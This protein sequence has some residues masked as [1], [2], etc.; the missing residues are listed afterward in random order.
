MSAQW[1]GEGLPP[2]GAVLQVAPQ[3]KSESGTVEVVGSHEARI[4]CVRLDGDEIGS[5]RS[6][7]ANELVPIHTPEQIAEDE[8]HAAI[9]HMVLQ[10]LGRCD[11][12][13]AAYIYDVGYRR[14][15][16]RAK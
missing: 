6:F 15:P 7:L 5:Y 8:R 12:I 2:V 1:S 9:Q 10:S 16:E 11:C 3:F 4:V 14:S 13:G